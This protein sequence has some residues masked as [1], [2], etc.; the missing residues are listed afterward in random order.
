MPGCKKLILP[1]CGSL[2]IQQSGQK[3]RQS[4]GH[5]PPFF[6]RLPFF[7]QTAAVWQIGSSLAL[8]RVVG[9]RHRKVGAGVFTKPVA[10]PGLGED[11]R[12]W[13]P[14]ESTVVPLETGPRAA[15][16][17]SQNHEWCSTRS[18]SALPEE[19]ETLQGLSKRCK[20]EARQ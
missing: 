19:S 20:N 3:N 5:M 7:C 11:A 2:A 14:G 15:F 12:T 4:G 10:W 1:D 18:R 9:S 13:S 17:R 6:A 8:K 16:C